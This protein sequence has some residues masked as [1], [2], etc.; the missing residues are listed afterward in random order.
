ML[1]HWPSD[2]LCPLLAGHQGGAQAS[3]RPV[4]S[5]VAP[6]LYK[7]DL[8]GAPP[9]HRDSLCWSLRPYPLPPWP[10]ASLSCHGPREALSWHTLPGCG[11][12]GREGPPF[13]GRAVLCL[14]PGALSSL[15]SSTC[16]EPGWNL[17][18]PCRV[19]LPSPSVYVSLTIL[20]APVPSPKPDT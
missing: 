6:P 15:L 4:L 17:A 10:D 14:K 20:L 19:V 8:A 13:A 18:R 16:P 12:T 7:Q 1:S 5:A 9:T 3:L 11:G 2:I